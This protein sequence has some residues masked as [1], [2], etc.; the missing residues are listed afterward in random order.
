MRKRYTTPAMQ[1][2]LMDLSHAVASATGVQGDDGTGWGGVDEGSLLDPEANSRDS[3][4][5][6]FWE[7]RE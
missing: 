4:E 1:E 5:E 2:T 7:G 3:R 6:D